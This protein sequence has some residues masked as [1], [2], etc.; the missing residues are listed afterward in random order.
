MLIM[1]LSLVNSLTYGAGE[2]SQSLWS[3]MGSPDYDE[4]AENPFALLTSE[5]EGI[6]NID[7]TWGGMT[8][9][10]KQAQKW[11]SKSYKLWRQWSG[12]LVEFSLE[13]HNQRKSIVSKLFVMHLTDEC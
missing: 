9:G 3:T 7:H 8:K 12:Y 1:G 10:A 13:P 6:D 11:L 5:F 4:E 2:K